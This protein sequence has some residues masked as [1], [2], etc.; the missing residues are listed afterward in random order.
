MGARKI[1]GATALAVLAGGSGLLGWRSLQTSAATAAPVVRTTTVARGTIQSTTAA[2]GNVQAASAL[3][4]GFETAGK[5]SE[6]LVKVGDAVKAGDVLG[7][8][9]ATDTTKAV[10]DATAALDKAKANRA[11][12]AL[13]VTNAFNKLAVAMATPVAASAASSGQSAVDQAQTKYDQTVTAADTAQT[14]VDTTADKLATAKANLAKTTLGAPSAGTVTAASLVV[15]QSVSAAGTSAAV[16]ATSSTSSTGAGAASGGTGSS[17]SGGVFAL[18]DLSTLQVQASVAEADSTKVRVGQPVAISFDALADTKLAGKVLSIGLTATVA[19]NVVSYPVAISLVNPPAT[20]RPGMTAAATIVTATRDGVLRLP[21]AA[22]R[23]TGSNGTVTVLDE[24]GMQSPR[25]VT[26]GVKGDDATEIVSG[27]AEGDRVVIATTTGA[28]TR[29]QTGTGT[30][31]QGNT[32]AGTPGGGF[33]A[34]GGGLP[35]G[36]PPGLG[37]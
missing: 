29:T 7:R 11:S 21:T 18:T 34:G 31:R 28:S 16:P 3:S 13:A 32:P 1:A 10:T 12:A 35:V 17:G 20:I 37:G 36:G 2:A 15:G 5:V 4:V 22:V 6:V 26:L 24:A 23:G 33:R 30:N 19:N 8:L 25:P 14:N 27:L 9:D